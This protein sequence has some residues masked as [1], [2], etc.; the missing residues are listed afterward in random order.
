ML[1][2]FILKDDKLLMNKPSDSS[3]FARKAL[4]FLILIFALAILL[5]SLFVFVTGTQDFLEGDG[6]NYYTM[7]QQLAQ[8]HVYSYGS[9]DPN[10][11]VTPGFPIFAYIVLSVS[12]FNIDLYKWVQI[13]IGA[14]TIFPVYYF[15]KANTRAVYGL[16]GALFVALYPPFIYMTGLFLTETLFVFLLALFFASWQRMWNKPSLWNI[17]LNAAL[18]SWGILTRPGMLPII[19]IAA[20]FL[21]LSKSKRRILFPYLLTV[22]V[23]FLPWVLRNYIVLHE[24]TILAAG[25]GNALLAGAFPY[26]KESANYTEMYALGLSQSQYGMRVILNGLSDQF[27]YYLG[28]F[29]YGKLYYLFSNMWVS[30][31]LNFPKLYVYGGVLL[32]YGITACSIPA[33]LYLLIKKN[34]MAFCFTGMLLFQ[35]LFI[36]TARYGAPFFILTV[37]SVGLAAYSLQKGTKQVVNLKNM[38]D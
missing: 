10:S 11:R 20:L 38:T 36:P 22:A 26:F 8:D 24:F 27:F 21:V 7:I 15:I 30:S 19:F 31:S 1:E 33:L 18:L 16:I 13:L 34:F 14:A 2:K 6:G 12:S 35:L 23:C 29:S 5:R 17:I 9:E 28:W 25:S 32:H 4:L 3:I 37:M